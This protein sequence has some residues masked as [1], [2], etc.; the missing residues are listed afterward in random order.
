MVI[1]IEGQAW[2]R[3]TVV[4]VEPG[5]SEEFANIILNS[6][7]RKFRYNEA[8]ASIGSN[9]MNSKTTPVSVRRTLSMKSPVEVSGADDCP[10]L[11]SELSSRRLDGILLLK[12]R[13]SCLMSTQCTQ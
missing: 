2:V 9:M 1:S 3:R 6:E 7:T 11:A 4:R 10:E 12:H 13:E 5:F 8:F